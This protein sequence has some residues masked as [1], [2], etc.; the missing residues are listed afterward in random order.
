MTTDSP[1]VRTVALTLCS[2][3]CLFR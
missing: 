1:T 2:N 3:H